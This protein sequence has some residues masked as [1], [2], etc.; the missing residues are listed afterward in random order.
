VRYTIRTV[1][2]A[3][4][5]PLPFTL[6]EAFKHLEAE[7]LAA[8]EA[9][10]AQ[11]EADL[12][13]AMDAV[14]RFTSQ[15]LTPRELVYAAGGFPCVPE[16]I[17]IPRDP[18]TAVTAIAYTDGDGEAVDLAEG[19]WRWSEHAP[20]TVMPAF[21]ASWPVAA[22]EPGSVRVT[23]TAGY[24]EGLV[25]GSL[26]G[27]VKLMLGT[28]YGNRESVVTGTIVSELPGGVKALCA[29]YRRVTL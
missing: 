17:V 4:L 2:P 9:E 12:R 26:I 16:L 20:D 13:A 7:E 8:D 11:V 14:E 22:A 6:A 28:L 23:F 10:Q 29:P 25:P 1:T 18:I 5:V 27:A 21:R 3:N 15:I 19:D 24:E